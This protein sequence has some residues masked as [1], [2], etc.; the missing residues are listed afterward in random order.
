MVEF[1]RP[2]ERPISSGFV[3]VFWRCGIVLA[4][5]GG[6]RRQGIKA[7]MSNKLA[8]L[9]RRNKLLG[10]HRHVGTTGG[11]AS[12]TSFLRRASSSPA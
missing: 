3:G 8:D 12:A 4:G 6:R 1:V 5:A 10:R 9:E 2:Y 11:D 7:E